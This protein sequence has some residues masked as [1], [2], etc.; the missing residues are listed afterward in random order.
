MG[1]I[2][3]VRRAYEKESF[4]REAM[5]EKQVM[6]M[7]HDPKKKYFLISTML[8]EQVGALAD[9]TRILAVRGVDILEGQIYTTME[10]HGYVTL[11]A[12]ARDAR[13]DVNFLKQILR[14]STFLEATVVLESHKGMIIDSVNFPL[15]TDFG[16]R[17][18]LLS[19]E[20][21]RETFRTT[22]EGYGKEAADL[23]YRLGFSYGSG[24]WS[25]LFTGLEKDKGSVEGFLAFY[26]A[27]GLGKATLER[28]RVEAS[29]LRVSVEGCFEC[30]G[31]EA[32]S[33]ASAFFLGVL[34]GSFGALFGRE[35]VAR[36][37]KCVAMG[38]KRCEFELTPRA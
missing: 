11:F 33:P 5:N 37:I 8:K 32:S 12:E 21:V 14:G 6:V 16:E 38:D 23:I 25:K 4:A 7:R 36:E 30:E 18:I 9:I 20:A 13:I 35:M 1:S 34:A 31:L 10:G 24:V 19:A 28:Y 17:S 15:V 27:V 3:H 29:I 26:S 2:S 22:R